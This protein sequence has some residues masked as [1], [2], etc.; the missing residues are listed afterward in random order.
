MKIICTA[1]LACLS[2][3]CSA[4]PAIESFNPESATVGTTVTITGNNFSATETN[5]IVYFGAVRATVTD[6]T[7]TT[8]TVIVPPGA[9]YHPVSVTTD[10]LTA[11]STKPFRPVFSGGE[12]IRLSALR[13][14][15]KLDEEEATVRNID[16]A[17][18]NNDGKT[19]LLLWFLGANKLSVYRNTTTDNVI[20]FDV[21][22]IPYEFGLETMAPDVDNDGLPDILLFHYEAAVW[23][24]NTSTGGSISFA[25][26][27]EIPLEVFLDAPEWVDWDQDGLGDIICAGSEDVYVYRHLVSGA[28]HSFADPVIFETG[29]NISENL[30]I[31]DAD[32]DNKPDV[33]VNSWLNNKVFCFRN[34]SVPGSIS[35]TSHL[36]NLPGDPH[37]AQFIDVDTDGKP[38]V[39][40]SGYIDD[41]FKMAFARNESEGAGDI[42]FA[43]EVH[44]ETSVDNFFFYPSDFNGD[45]KI[46]LLLLG[47]NSYS[48]E[49]ISTVGSPEFKT[50]YLSGLNI[51]YVSLLTD[52]DHDG[53]PDIATSDGDLYVIRNQVG[54]PFIKSFGPEAAPPEAEI[55]IEG[56]YFSEVTEVTIGGAPASAF[57]IVSDLQINARVGNG[58]SGN[59]MVASPNG[60]FSLE[61]FTLMEEPVVTS[62]SPASGIA[63]Q[64]VMISGSN[65]TYATGVTLGGTAVTAF[66]VISDIQISA[67]IAEGPS[68]AVT[69]IT[70]AGEAV[71]E[72]LFEYGVITGSEM[73]HDNK[74]HIYPNPVVSKSFTVRLEGF[75]SAKP[76]ELTLVDMTGK[77]VSLMIM[78]SSDQGFTINLPQNLS[79]GIYV[80]K[81][82]VMNKMFVRKVIIR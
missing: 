59:L 33:L 45:G 22:D 50:V 77:A 46:D 9:D 70:P 29:S 40:L 11:W 31:G 39:V 56:E 49:N 73:V 7:T 21:T 30:S 25:A 79:V 55:T 23:F 3:V 58:T 75:Q 76:L 64:V 47:N 36:L 44:N 24:R 82:S 18:F 14:P 42:S 57:E 81:I 34:T 19:D 66:T 62:F 20:S 28:V 8:L 54:E 41:V 72:E 37:G 61:G 6:A 63:G 15:A 69:V 65:F 80:L 74:V 16:K 5:N 10:A 12:T 78:H 71:S 51:F 60:N 43:P 35:A 38:D 1:V 26:P 32:G 17:D 52:F 27:V 53:K 13:N 2:W 68:G 4:Q 67:V 48:M